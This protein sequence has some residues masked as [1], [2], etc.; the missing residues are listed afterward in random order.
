MKRQIVKFRAELPNMQ[1][2]ST[3]IHARASA[4]LDLAHHNVAHPPLYDSRFNQ[5]QP[6]NAQ[7]GHR[8]QHESQ[9]VPPR[10]AHDRCP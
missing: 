10:Y 4:L 5:K 1:M 2:K 8:E 6:G 9:P 3:K 7:P